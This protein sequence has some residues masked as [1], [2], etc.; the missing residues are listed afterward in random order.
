MT[1]HGKGEVS[2]TPAHQWARESHGSGEVGAGQSPIPPAPAPRG[3][4]GFF[5]K[6]GQARMF[7]DVEPLSSKP[8]AEGGGRTICV[9]RSRSGLRGRPPSR[10]PDKPTPQSTHPTPRPLTPEILP[11]MSPEG[12]THTTK[13]R[14]IWPGSPSQP[15]LPLVL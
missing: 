15:E 5:Q 10:G 1:G 3:Q 14:A 9:R 7:T 12:L 2:R 4:E 8:T 13:D 11:V 6:E